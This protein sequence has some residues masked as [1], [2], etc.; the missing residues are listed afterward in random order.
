MKMAKD[1][2]MIRKRQ[3]Q[4]L[5]SADLSV[6]FARETQRKKAE[7]KSLAKRANPN[8]MTYSEFLNVLM[9]VAPKVYPEVDPDGAFPKLLLEN[10]CPLAAHR[11]VVKVDEEMEED[12]VQELLFGRFNDGLQGIFDYYSDVADRRRKLV[13]AQEVQDQVKLKGGHG[14]VQVTSKVRGRVFGSWHV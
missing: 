13:A 9:L 14:Q 4:G 11:I 5:T 3:S 1:C 10:I 7:N 2:Q 6:I 8:L 12:D